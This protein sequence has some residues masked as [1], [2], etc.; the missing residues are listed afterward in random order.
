MLCMFLMSFLPV[1]SLS[2]HTLTSLCDSL[3]ISF[4][5]YFCM[6]IEDINDNDDMK[7]MDEKRDIR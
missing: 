6:T 2:L 5:L 1:C 3:F 7:K 4:H